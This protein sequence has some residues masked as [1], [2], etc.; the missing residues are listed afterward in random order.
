MT[1]DGILSD[2]YLYH[3][4]VQYIKF[5]LPDRLPDFDVAPP[6]NNPENQKMLRH[7]DERIASYCCYQ[8]P[9]SM[10]WMTKT[11]IDGLPD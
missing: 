7:T 2:Y 10:F 6:D 5:V 9:G 1:P 3:I 8:V 4:L 11:Y